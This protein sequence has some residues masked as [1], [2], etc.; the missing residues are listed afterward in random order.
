MLVKIY[1]IYY[2]TLE[3]QSKKDHT[4]SINDNEER[5][6]KAWLCPSLKIGQEWP[7]LPR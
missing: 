1:S 5:T 2:R 7:L 3:F 6:Q 4:W